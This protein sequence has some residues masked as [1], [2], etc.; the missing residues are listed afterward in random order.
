MAIRKAA[1]AVE[2]LIQIQRLE[3]AT[4]TM[5]LLGTSALIM[6][7]MAAKAKQHILYPP[8]KKNQAEREQVMKHDPIAEFRDAIYRCRDEHAPTLVHVPS[9]AFKKAMAQAAIDTPGATKAETGRLVKLLDETV[10]IYGK[11]FL[12]MAVVRTAGMSKTPDIR[13]RALFKQWACKITVQYIRQKIREQ[14][15][16]NLLANAGD[17]TGVGDGRTE[18]GTFDYGSWEIVHENDPRWREIVKAGGRKVQEGAMA[19]PECSDIDTEEL[20]AW[21][22]KEVI[23]READRH[24]PKAPTAAVIAAGK[25]NGRKRRPGAEAEEGEAS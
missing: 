25:S 3:R 15:I 7:R 22:Q 21:Y 6:N 2:Q 18:K 19:N 10:H 12:Y 17:V 20:Y 23:R 16:V 14:D 5:Y 8:R 11:P 4:V 13:T 24:A 1:E 9:G